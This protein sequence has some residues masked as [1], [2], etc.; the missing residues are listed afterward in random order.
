MGKEFNVCRSRS[1][2]P[3]PP[4]LFHLSRLLPIVALDD[5]W[6]GTPESTE[7]TV[8]FITGFGDTISTGKF[9]IRSNTSHRPKESCQSTQRFYTT[10]RPESNSLSEAACEWTFFADKRHCW[11]VGTS[12][13]HRPERQVCLVQGQAGRQQRRLKQLRPALEQ[14]K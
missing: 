6:K 13:A 3:K 1:P 2:C 8:A 12:T 4:L 9:K 5:V 14:H 7:S 10:T 11:H